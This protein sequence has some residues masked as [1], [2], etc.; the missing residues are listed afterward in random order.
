MLV[1]SWS[2]ESGHHERDVIHR[3]QVHI[4]AEQPRRLQ[5]ALQDY[6]APHSGRGPLIEI[7]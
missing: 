5:H 6:T 4:Q 7:G 1:H 2:I 3:H